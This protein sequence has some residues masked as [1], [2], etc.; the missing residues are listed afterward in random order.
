MKPP[1]PPSEN[2]LVL[3][4]NADYPPAHGETVLYLCNAGSDYNR[5]KDNFYQWNM[6]LTCEANNTFSSEPD[7]QWPTCVNGSNY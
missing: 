5:F 1:L 2:K 4:W 3:Q 7:V 6:T